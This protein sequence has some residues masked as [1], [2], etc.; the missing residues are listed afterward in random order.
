MDLMG[1]DYLVQHLGQYPPPF[2]P[3][4]ALL[5]SGG[6]GDERGVVDRTQS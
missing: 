2:L 3:S 5:I 4:H 1:R 6:W